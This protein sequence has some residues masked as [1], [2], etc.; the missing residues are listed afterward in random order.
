MP[1]TLSDARMIDCVWL[2]SDRA[3]RLAVLITAGEGPIPPAALDG[4]VEFFEIETLLLELP[5]S[6]AAHLLVQVPSPD[7]FVALAERGL[8]V[9]DWTDVHRTA[10]KTNAYELVAT[11]SEPQQLASLPDDL[12]RTAV[13]LD[14][15][16]AGTP[17]V[18]RTSVP[19]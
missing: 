5:V 11:P 8:F 17:Q 16:F 6:A 4:P 10:G 9:Y 7:S 2:A 18:S 15:E 3:G 1:T 14:L 13:G 12:R 19:A